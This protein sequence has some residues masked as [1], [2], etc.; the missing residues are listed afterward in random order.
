MQTLAHYVREARNQ[1]REAIERAKV[2]VWLRHPRIGFPFALRILNQ[3]RPCDE[4]RRV[5]ILCCNHRFHHGGW[6][7]LSIVVT[8]L[9]QK[10]Q[11]TGDP[12]AASGE[13]G[14]GSVPKVLTAAVGS[15]KSK[16]ES[17]EQFGILGQAP[18][19]SHEAL[20]FLRGPIARGAI[21]VVPVYIVR[22]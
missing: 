8:R 13:S 9:T 1:S 14:Y 2:L 7:D 16:C 11:K 18:Q 3:K 19:K 17:N 22:L 12:V 5:N 20:L 6:K 4:S 10:P 15:V 21:G